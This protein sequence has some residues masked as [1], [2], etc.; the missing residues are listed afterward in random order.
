MLINKLFLLL[1]ELSE[2]LNF[3]VNINSYNPYKPKLFQI[4][5]DIFKG[6]KG[7]WEQKFDHFKLS[8]TR[9]YQAL[10]QILGIFI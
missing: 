6:I 5:N 7:S 2:F 8:G 10:C 4:L 9:V 1:N 3:S